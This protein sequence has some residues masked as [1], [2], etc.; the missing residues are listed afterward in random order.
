MATY[1][2]YA[3]RSAESQVNWAEVGKNMTDMLQEQARVRQDKINALDEAARQFGEE[4]SNAPQGEHVGATEESLRFA[5]DVSQYMLMKQ[6]LWKSGDMS[7][8]DYLIGTQ[9]I[10]DGTKKALSSVKAFQEN[11]AKLMEKAVTDVSSKIEL[12]RLEKVQGYGNFK[13]S[14][15][16]IDPTT[17]KVNVALK[18][19]QIIDGKK[20]ITMKEGSSR[21][22]QYIDGA[23]NGRVDKFKYLEPLTELSKT[24]GEEIRTAIDPSTISK[25]GTIK[26]INDL[27]QRED[28]DS[29][30]KKILFHYMTSVTDS[31]NALIT[32]PLQRGSLLIDTMGYDWTDDPAEAAKDPMMVLEVTDPNT[33]RGELKFTKEQEQA[34]TDFLVQ[35]FLGMQT[36][37]EEARA[38]GQTSQLRD[39]TEAQ[40]GRA[41]KKRDAVNLAE[42]LF[43]AISGDANQA[44]LGTKFLSGLSGIKFQK[45]KDS[46]IVVDA[47]GNQQTYNFTADGKVADPITFVKSF[48]GPIARELN[49]NQDDVLREVKRLLPEGATLNL[50]T[51][52]TGFDETAQ[53]GNPIEKVVNAVNENFSSPTVSGK[54]E[55]Y[56]NAITMAAD[57]NNDLAS[58]LGTN[59]SFSTGS[60][61]P[62][63]NIFVKVGS[64][65]SPNYS[66]GS[67]EK[68][69]LAISKMKQFIIDNLTAGAS[70]EEKEMTAEGAMKGMRMP[71]TKGGVG[72]KY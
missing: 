49:I 28:I 65:E 71:A 43:F 36:R 4:L 42:N 67:A 13:D 21:G 25:M 69:K 20:V 24:Y 6:R 14:G 64:I 15:F 32:N 56:N 35:Q 46:F 12:K 70:A 47:D 38:I 37:K 2:K 30:T 34:S 5:D 58:N 44:A 16:F 57:L 50:T 54:I 19:M 51:E 41:D 60:F 61:N 11:Y 48:I 3:E 17:G 26:S 9:N 29:D 10:M 40:M 63:G 1:F 33:G 22:M 45:T 72:A 23:I 7:T 8:K 52:A 62:R 55:S 59:V 39:P 68:N 18:D 53:G 66:V 27:R 31:V